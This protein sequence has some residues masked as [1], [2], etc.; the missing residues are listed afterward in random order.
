MGWPWRNGF[1]N[2]DIEAAE[3]S[4]RLQEAQHWLQRTQPSTPLPSQQQPP[5]ASIPKA[6]SPRMEE[7]IKYFQR[8]RDFWRGE[9]G[10]PRDLTI[11]IEL[12]KKSALADYPPALYQLGKFYLTGQAVPINETAGLAHLRKAWQLGLSDNESDLKKHGYL[13]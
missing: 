9:N 7:A 10:H 8:G 5:A 2:S 6:G 12:L 1:E 11:A 3:Y 13:F 4:V